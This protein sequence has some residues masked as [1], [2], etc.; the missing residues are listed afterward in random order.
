MGME[1]QLL[2]INCQTTG[3]NSVI[4]RL[5]DRLMLGGGT[6]R[7]KSLNGK[8]C[9]DHGEHLGGCHA[10]RT[11]ERHY[12]FDEPI[13]M[14]QPAQIAWASCASLGNL[15]E[16]KVIAYELRAGLRTAPCTPETP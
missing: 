11:R 7:F 12:S 15:R 13:V 2:R 6:A 8:R 3:L 16:V 9:A 4:Q 10:S 14:G 5:G 1:S